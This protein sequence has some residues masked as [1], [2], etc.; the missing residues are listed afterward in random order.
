MVKVETGGRRNIEKANKLY[1]R[2]LCSALANN[3]HRMLQREQEDTRGG[4]SW[5][6]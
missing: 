6:Y 1:L 3:H 5:N 4:S 2:V